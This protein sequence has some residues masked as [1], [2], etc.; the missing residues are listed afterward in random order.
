M[1]DVVTREIVKNALT[2]LADEM[3]LTVIRTAHSQVVRD[4]MDF[5]TV[6][7]GPRG[8]VIAQGATLP[9]HLGAM[10][11]AMEAV[12]RKYADDIWPGDV[13]ILNDPDEGGMHL[14]DIFLFQ[15]IFDGDVRVGFAGITAHQADIGGRVPGGNAVDS[16]DI[17]QEGLQIPLLKLYDRGVEN[18]AIMDFLRR[19]VRVPE[20]VI[21]DVRAQLAAAHTADKRLLELVRRY[22]REELMAYMDDILDATE[23]H[24]RREIAAMPDGTYAFEDHIDDDG[25][26]SG[27]LRI[28]VAL[29]VGGDELSIDFDG[30]S[31]QVRSALNA[32]LSIVKAAVYTALMCV[33]DTSSGLACNDGFTRPI[34]IAAAEGSLLNARRPAAR[35]ARGLTAYRVVDA[36]FGALHR[37]VPSRVPAAGDGGVTVVAFGTTDAAGRSSVLV[38]TPVAGWGARPDQDGVDGISSLAANM[39]NTPVEVMESEFPVR[40]EEYGFVPDT[41]GAGRFRGC[42]SVV[43]QYRFLA[44]EGILQI[45]SD[46]RAFVPY[47]LAGGGDG[48]PSNVT[49]NP[50]VDDEQLPSKVTQTIRHGDVIRVVVAGGGGYGDPAGR[51]RE[52]VARDIQDELLSPG[53]AARLYG[54]PLSALPQE[55]QRDQSA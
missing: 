35:A 53:R 17:F 33:M 51:A 18:Q 34:R 6:L 49:L 10:P 29:T 2:S 27:P 13:F 16:T 5:A 41:G 55:D 40:I 20:L 22:G 26:G 46:R 38:D 23:A 32:T 7:F 25:L 52:A 37:V 44:P 50:G 12:L 1:S 42:A 31:G 47:G 3:A 14:P 19:N 45:R 36:V 54:H 4:T 28:A 24:V 15:P 39:A 11:D 48:T 30:S 8:D 9:L 43:R 21:G